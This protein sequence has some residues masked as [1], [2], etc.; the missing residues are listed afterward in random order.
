M[1]ALLGEIG[2]D[3]QRQIVRRFVQQL[4]AQHPAVAV[5]DLAAGHDIFDIAVAL[6]PKALQLERQPVWNQFIIDAAFQPFLVVIAIAGIGIDIVF[7]C[8]RLGDDI[9]DPG[10][11]IAAKQRALR[12]AQHFDSF[13][14]AQIRQAGAGAATVDAIDEQRHRAFDAHVFADRADAA[15]PGRE[16]S[17]VGRPRHQ[18]RWCQLIERADIGGAGIGQLRGGDGAD[19]D[20]NIG[21]RLCTPG[22]R[23]DDVRH[24]RRFRRH[25]LREGRH[26]HGRCQPGAERTGQAQSRQPR[27]LCRPR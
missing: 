8:G 6:V 9:D 23:H 17:L 11:S 10:G 26:S 14:F 13:D 3:A 7:E 19:G 1:F 21:Q 18:Q 22:R 20:G 15:N 4:P 25:N 27:R 12:P 24:D 5:V 2:N 16:H